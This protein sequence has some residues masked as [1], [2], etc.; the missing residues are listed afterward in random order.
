MLAYNRLLDEDEH[1]LQWI[2]TN[3]VTSRSYAQNEPGRE[4]TGLVPGRATDRRDRLDCS[5]VVGEEKFY[6]PPRNLEETVEESAYTGHAEKFA[7]RLSPSVRLPP[8]PDT[9][10]SGVVAGKWT[11]EGRM[12]ATRVQPTRYAKAAPCRGLFGAPVVVP[13]AEVELRE[14]QA[15]LDHVVQ[16]S[17]E[18]CARCY[19]QIEV[20][21]YQTLPPEAVSLMEPPERSWLVRLHCRRQADGDE[22]WEV[23]AIVALRGD[24]LCLLFP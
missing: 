20:L 18:A 19:R 4:G 17:V 21:G 23:Q 3:T 22:A 2:V 13:C 8:L 16:L 15:L 24:A 9:H 1:Q 7:K 12:S 11:K 5:P 6:P 14:E 10:Q